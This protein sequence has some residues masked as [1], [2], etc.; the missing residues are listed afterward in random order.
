M[1]WIGGVMPVQTKERD[2]DG[3][4]ISPAAK[5]A[6]ATNWH[7]RQMNDHVYT[8]PLDKDHA[9]FA[10]NPLEKGPMANFLT[11]PVAATPKPEPRGRFR[12]VDGY[13]N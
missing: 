9:V 7:G 12:A 11:K 1:E 8:G 6:L 5:A 10:Y 13:Y 4:G 2:H 3:S